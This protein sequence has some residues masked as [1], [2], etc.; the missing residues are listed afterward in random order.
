MELEKRYQQAFD[1]LS[2]DVARRIRE[3]RFTALGYTSNLDFLCDFDVFLLN[4]L[5]EEN[6]PNEDL[7]EMKCAERI[8]TI[9]EL[10]E[11]LVYYCSRG[12]GGEVDV[13]NVEL[14]ANSFHFRYGMGGTATQAA[15]ALSQVGC[16]T[17]VHLTD[18][19][20]EVCDILNSP[21]IFAVSQDGELVHTKNLV[22]RNE[23]EIH[24]II[25]FKKGD[26]IRL[27][28]QE[29]EIP[30]SNRL[31]LT[32]VTVNQSVPFSKPYFEWI[33]KNAEKVSSNVL[34]S[35]N[36]LTDKEVLEEHLDYV[37]KHI[38]A[39]RRNNSEGIVFFE[40][41][42][43]HDF[44]IRKTCLETI[45]SYVDIVSLNE[46]EL[47]YTL[48]DMYH[49]QVNIHNVFS[50]IEGA[51]FI[52]N[53]FG[54]HKGVIIHTKDYSMYVGD[55]LRADIEKGLMYGNMLAT[56]KA[57]NGSYGTKKQIK[58]V[59]QFELSPNGMSKY[60]LIQNSDYK[61]EVVFVPSKYID[62]PRYTIGLGDSFVGGVQICF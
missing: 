9:E 17:I 29:M 36:C 11:T 45:Y 41:A 10:L 32:K 5:L 15:M 51:R 44:V 34:S 31:I 2:E 52:R 27:K 20:K 24:F 59:L 37:K 12:I 25:Q 14:I 26:I 38:Q 16:P 3:D 4:E 18:D 61:K 47:K 19:S 1:S 39:Y 48:N 22:Q 60:Y 13:D 53:K 49:F 57:K 8:D 30:F 35:F 46:D 23:Q 58:E 6:M 40:D 50:C 54:I 55:K 56:A 42:H 62:K 21:Y 33:E 28:N 7:F 43:Y